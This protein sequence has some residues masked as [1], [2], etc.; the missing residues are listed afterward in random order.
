MYEIYALLTLKKIPVSFV[1]LNYLKIPKNKILT[2]GEAKI[3]ILISACLC[4]INCKYNGKNNLHPFF[5][6]L[7]KQGKALPVC[8]E[9][10]GGLPT[11]RDPAE[12][13]GGDGLNVLQGKG[14]VISK[15]DQDLTDNFIRGA[16]ETMQIA[17]NTGASCA[18]LKSRSPSCG[19]D[20]I[21]DGNFSGKVISGDG[22][23]TALLKQYG[24]KVLSDK[25]FLEE[26]LENESY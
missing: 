6:E 1:I 8:P 14:Q 25:L 19:V 7:V 9:Q 10:L 16:Y 15:V 23:T 20:E 4:G 5:M 24:I 2:E 26:V 3:M 17:K 11:P 18:V 22:V 21:Y 13:S 12:I